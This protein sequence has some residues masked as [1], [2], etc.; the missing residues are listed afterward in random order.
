VAEKREEVTNFLKE[1]QCV[2]GAL[3]AGVKSGFQRGENP[4]FRGRR[5]D[6][7]TD[8]GEWNKSGG[9]ERINSGFPGNNYFDRHP[10]YR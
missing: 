10:F 9:V 4:Q 5:R 6:Q 2:Y 1:L 8:S 3:V 7:G